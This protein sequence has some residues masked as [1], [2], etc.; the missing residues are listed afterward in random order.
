MSLEWTTDM[1]SNYHAKWLSEIEAIIAE[2]IQ[3][4]VFHDHDTW[5]GYRGPLIT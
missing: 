2:D 1:C 4:D 5:P 3:D